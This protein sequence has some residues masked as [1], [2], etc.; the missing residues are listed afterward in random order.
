MRKDTRIRPVSIRPRLADGI[1][2]DV[3]LDHHI[4]RRVGALRSLSGQYAERMR[5]RLR[6][7]P[8]EV[9]FPVS[10]DDDA[11]LPARIWRTSPVMSG[12][13]LTEEARAPP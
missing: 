3:F 4:A 6:Q 2:Y 9:D 13:A 12:P 7:G 8:Y 11:P 1:F 10:A 5:R